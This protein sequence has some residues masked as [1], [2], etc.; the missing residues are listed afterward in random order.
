MYLAASRPIALALALL[1]MVCWGSWSNAL[2]FCGNRA[3]FELFYWDFTWGIMLA[4]T[5]GALTVGSVTIPGCAG[6]S[7]RFA[8]DDFQVNPSKIGLAICA[9]AVFNLANMMLT[10]GI[11]LCGLA[12]A[13]PLCIGTALVFG[14]LLT[15]LLEGAK[16]G[17]SAPLLFLGVS[18]AFVSVCGTSLVHR[19]KDQAASATPD[20]DKAATSDEDDDPR[21][22][23]S[24]CPVAPPAGGDTDDDIAHCDATVGGTG[25]S[26]VPAEQGPST[27]AKLLLCLGGGAFMAVWSPLNAMAQHGFG[28]PDPAAG[29][30]PYGAFFFFSVGIMLS[31]L[32][33][34]PLALRFPI[35]GQRI[36]VRQLAGECWKAPY[37]A[38]FYG[39]AGGI[40]WAIGTLANAV[41]GQ[42]L[43][44]AVS[45][46]IGQSAPMVSI[47][48]GVF[49][50]HEFNG[51][52]C[53][54]KMLLGLVCL[55]YML[56]IALV[57]LSQ[58]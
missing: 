11:Q 57:A 16:E 9:G 17:S 27:A 25:E 7:A 4:A 12:L 50:F 53:I 38:H 56:S 33:L 44:F 1:S 49:M 6:C 51:V 13:F 26:A 21:T 48:W 43:S 2:M 58:G 37:I 46:A 5:V 40:V 45:Y 28:G 30:S 42:A 32:V 54:V 47:F 31:T 55:L 36:S 20:A 8:P 41:S 14:T 29:L 35:D 10:K 39:L 15:Y 34:V 52:P 18:V 24:C 23:M 19:L 3:R 22:P